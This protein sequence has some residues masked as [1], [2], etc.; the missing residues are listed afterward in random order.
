MPA[1]NW[2]TDRSIKL[3]IVS[4]W[5]ALLGATAAGIG[6]P[7]LSRMAYKPN[8]ILFDSARF[9]SYAPSI[10]TCLAIGLFALVVLLRLLHDI[11]RGQVFTAANVRRIRLVAW[12]ALAIGAVCLLS[13]ALLDHR[14]TV[15]VIGLAAVFC[16]LV[17]R[18]LK[19]VLD[20][21]RLLKEDADFTI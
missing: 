4:T 16:G 20:A 3:S 2:T 6:L 15:F 10:Y 18:V 14:P 5:A 21:A 17:A 8:T 9:V 19:N 1:T 7:F 12:C 11:A 13:A